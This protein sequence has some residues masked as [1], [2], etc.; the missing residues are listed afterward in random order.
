[1]HLTL[2]TLIEAHPKPSGWILACAALGVV[3][4]TGAL[5]MTRA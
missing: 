5:L 4:Y 1:M 2:D 3:V